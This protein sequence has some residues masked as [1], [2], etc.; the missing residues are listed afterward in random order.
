[1]CLNC[2]NARRSTIH[3]PRLVAARDQA[4]QLRQQ[5]RKTGPVPVLQQMAIDN[6]IA[7]LD[8]LLTNLEPQAAP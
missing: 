7:E 8:Q 2:P 1:M 5:C 6:H 4:E 3:R